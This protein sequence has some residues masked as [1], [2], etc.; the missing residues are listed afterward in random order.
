[1]GST[2][3]M[4]NE[5]AYRS[6]VCAIVH[7]AMRGLYGDGLIDQA[8]MRAFDKLCLSR[9]DGSDGGGSR[10]GN[11]APPQANYRAANLAEKPGFA[12]LPQIRREHLT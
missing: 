10:R 12:S 8:T 4:Q 5:H 1:M 6:K 2:D 9:A 11:T 3:M 7:E